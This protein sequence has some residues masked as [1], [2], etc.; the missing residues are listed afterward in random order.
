MSTDAFVN[1]TAIQACAATDAAECLSLLLFGKKICSSV[2]KQDHIK[3]FGAIVFIALPRT[4]SDAVVSSNVLSGAMR[5]KQ[6]P[7]KIEVI[8]R[9]NYFFYT[10]N[11]DL[12]FRK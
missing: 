5:S 1:G 4:G 11:G 6:W 2:V 8:N 9:R 12:H 7:I 10:G 3:F